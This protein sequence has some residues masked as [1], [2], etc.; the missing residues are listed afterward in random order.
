M[1]NARKPITILGA[2]KI[3][4]A[5]A[6]LLERSGDY[7]VLVAD[8]DPARLQAV[9]ELGCDTA[10]VTDDA[11]LQSSITGRYAVL[12]ALPFHRAITVAGLCASAGVHYFDLTEDVASTHAIQALATGARSVLM[13][14]CGLAP[15]FIGI[16]GNSLAS[17]FD[18]LHDL[19]MR[20]GALPRYPSNGLRY[21]LTWS[22]EGLINEYCNP[23][24]SIVDGKLTTVP[25]LEG[26]ETFA[27][28]GV[29]YEAF[30]TSGGLGTLP[31]TL[32]GKARNVDYKSVRYPGHCNIMKLLLND[33]RLRDRRDLL[34]DIFESAIPA[35]DQDVIVILASAS[36]Y[37][38]KRLQ[39]ESF[40][41]SIFGADVD[42]HTLSAIQL[43]TAAGICAALDLVA[44]GSLPQDGFVGQESITLESML[45][46]RF[47]RVYSG[48]PVGIAATV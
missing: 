43:S 2:G 47:G 11:S 21:N 48:K 45:E 25:A 19:R 27:L 26:Y 12:N 7:S 4:F 18:T 20:V 15:G 46:N 22:T 24:E 38:N 44:Q 9:A 29:E 17:H 3:G 36:G 28:D 41:T 37:R 14:Q 23:C 35:T 16:A 31:E 1:T 33:L 10:L 39:Q 30:N 32:L 8:Q 5:I 34:K 13:P 40:T 42:G 6:L